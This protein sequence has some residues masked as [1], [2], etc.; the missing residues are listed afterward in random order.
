MSSHLV[1]DRQVSTLLLL[2]LRLGESGMNRIATVLAM[3]PFVLIFPQVGWADTLCGDPPPVA[4]DSLKGEIDGRAKFLSSFL[5][6]A[7]LVGRIETSRKEIFSRYK[8]A[9]ERSNAY[10]EYQVCILLMQDITMTTSQKIDVLTSI[11]RE[12]RKPI[13]SKTESL[14]PSEKDLRY[15]ERLTED[16][17]ESIM[18]GD[19]RFILSITNT[20]FFFDQKVLSNSKEIRAHYKNLWDSKDVVEQEIK[21]DSVKSFS[22]LQFKRE[23]PRNAFHDRILNS[24]LA[25]A[26]TDI[27]VLVMRKGEGSLFFYRKFDKELKMIGFWG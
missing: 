19:I 7:E 5:G 12:F 15:A 1:K 3:L 17:F 14:E 25:V 16:W 22:I 2:G 21:I 8:N 10:F 6:N 27:V 20:P 13:P 26:D 23:Y 11:R 4:E 9:D 24:P 18:A